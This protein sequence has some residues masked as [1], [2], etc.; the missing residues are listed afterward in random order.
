MYCEVIHICVY[1]FLRF[2]YSYA[3]MNICMSVCI[4][5]IHTRHTY[6]LLQKH[7]RH[8][9]I[10]HVHTCSY[11]FS[12]CLCKRNRWS[13]HPPQNSTQ[14][15]EHQVLNVFR[16]ELNRLAKCTPLCKFPECIHVCQ[17]IL[18]LRTQT[19]MLLQRHYTLSLNV[20]V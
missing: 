8:T 2:V 13:V 20:I 5:V 17:Y 15:V 12:P 11:M 14:S 19:Y 16:E 10:I 3:C 6:R 1:C 7:Y 18:T 9:H 4:C